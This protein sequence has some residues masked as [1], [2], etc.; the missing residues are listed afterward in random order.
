MKTFFTLFAS[1]I[2]TS[3]CFGQII[4]NEICYDPS[5]VDLEGDTNGDG[6]YA[7]SEDEF[8]EFVN[9]GTDVIDMSGWKVFDTENLE[10]DMLPPNH[11][12]PDGTTLL[13]GAAIVVFGGGTPTGDFGFATVQ[14]STSGDMNLNNSGDIMTLTDE[15]DMVILTFDIEPLSNNPNESYTRNPDLTG[16]FEQHGDNTPVLFS[17][18]TQIDGTPFSIGV[19]S[20]TV[21]GMG[22]ASSI[23]TDGGTLQMMASVMP[24]NASI[25][26]VNWSI[27]PATGIASID[28]NGLLT[29]EEDGTVTVTA[30]S[31]DGTNVSGSAEITITNNSAI[32]VETV[33]V[34]GM[35]GAT[36]I[37]APG[38]TLQLEAEVLPANATDGSVS[39][40]IDPA[41]GTAS[42]SDMGL[43]TAEADGTVT[44]T[45]TAND[46]SGVSGSIEITITNQDLSASVEEQNPFKLYPNPSTG[47]IFIDSDVSLE[48]GRVFSLDG[49]LLTAE[50]SIESNSVDISSYENGVYIISL[51]TGGSTYSTRILKY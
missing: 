26:N 21:E 28:G 14:T 20:I 25:Q 37:D 34:T 47:V 44:V 50:V 30:T 23:D 43:V 41:M 51:D 17:P 12:F 11:V 5:N 32:L 22:G 27:E 24:A 35:G 6:Q 33:N 9:N 2:L 1:L 3:F 13:P 18:G 49:R 40:S 48:S 7:Q 10:D 31:T 4:L 46:G 39:W 15:N 36:S 38:G 8:L 29:A 16:E 42:V 45:A 19:S